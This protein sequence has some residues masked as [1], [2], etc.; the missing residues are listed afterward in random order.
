MTKQQND[1]VPS[2]DSDQLGHQPSL[3][4]VFAVSL[5]GS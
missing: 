5:M 1:C 4:R 2:E 3:I